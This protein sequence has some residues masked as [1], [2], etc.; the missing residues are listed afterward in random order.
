MYIIGLAALLLIVGCKK[1]NTSDVNTHPYKGT[2]RLF[3]TKRNLSLKYYNNAYA[4]L[5]LSL[6]TEELLEFIPGTKANQ[7]FIRPKD[8]PEWCLDYSA[9]NNNDLRLYTYLGNEAQLFTVQKVGE[10]LVTIQ[11]V[12]DTALYLLNNS[13]YDS[14]GPSSY[15]K[16]RG[17]YSSLDTWKIEIL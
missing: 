3:E 15:L 7:Y 17:S 1:E 14:F 13:D 12:V 2:V 16:P 10:D 11:C 9:K 6:G 8:H 5:F 4:G